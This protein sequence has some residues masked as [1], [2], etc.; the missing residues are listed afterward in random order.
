MN[1]GI[2]AFSFGNKQIGAMARVTPGAFAG[3]YAPLTLPGR[4]E[5]GL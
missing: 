4:A 3:R 1:I 5:A 2:S